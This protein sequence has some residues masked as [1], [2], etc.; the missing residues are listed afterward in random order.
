MSTFTVTDK[1]REIMIK[2]ESLKE[3][4]RST[5]QLSLYFTFLVAFIGVF[6]S[7]SARRFAV[8]VTAFLSASG[9]LA[10]KHFESKEEEARKELNE[11]I[12]IEAS[13]LN[14]ERLI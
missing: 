13:R 1:M 8:P 11:A 5:A 10:S 2:I 4:S 3:K 14:L 6:S 12:L 7:D 9:W